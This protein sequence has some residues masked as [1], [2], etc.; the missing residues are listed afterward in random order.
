MTTA[1]VWLVLGVLGVQSAG[2]PVGGAEFSQ[3]IILFYFILQ[4]VILL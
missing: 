4:K 2:E 1:P 3:G